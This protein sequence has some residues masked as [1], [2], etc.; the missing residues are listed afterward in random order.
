MLRCYII[1]NTYLTKPLKNNAGR[2]E[3]MWQ[4]L[5]TNPTA[6]FDYGER[7]HHDFRKHFLGARQNTVQ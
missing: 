7:F 1:F 6:Q 5:W 4:R 2:F 3:D